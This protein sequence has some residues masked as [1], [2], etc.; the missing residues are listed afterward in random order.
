MKEFIICAA[1]RNEDNGEIFYGHRYTHC[2]TAFNDTLSW[3]LNREQIS[4]VKK[5]Q[6]FITNLNRFVDRKEALV[7]A[8]ESSQIIP[9]RQVI[10]GQLY[11]ED[12]Y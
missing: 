3:A 10:G 2:I 6:G 1:I 11:S 8:S 9:E 7:I 5:T 4:K 12:L